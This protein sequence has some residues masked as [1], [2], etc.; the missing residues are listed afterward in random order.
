MKVLVILCFLIVVSPA[1]AIN[2]L[3]LKDSVL[4]G[5]TKED[6]SDFKGFVRGALDATPDHKV[7]GWRSESGSITGKFKVKVTYQFNNETCR[8]SYFLF[9]SQG[10]KEPYSFEIC[11][12]G[13]KW[14]FQDTP[15]KYFK[16]TDWAMLN[17]S[18]M[19]ALNFKSAGIPTSWYNKDT[20]NSGS[21]VVLLTGLE[22]SA[23]KEVAISILDNTGR[24]SNGVYK[25]CRSDSGAWAREIQSES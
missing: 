25:F 21:H 22:G 12:V 2:L 8:R 18:V 10:K 3:F 13:D 9:T 17:E 4:T 19:Q 15:A 23:C 20:K 11:K 24:S 1:H 16:A 6:V 5:L 14:I 7:V